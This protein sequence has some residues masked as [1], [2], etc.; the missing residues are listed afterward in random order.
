MRILLSPALAAV[1]DE[2]E[3]AGHR[4]DPW[5]PEQADAPADVVIAAGL[6]EVKMAAE[7]PCHVIAVVEETELIGVRRFGARLCDFCVAPVRDG[8]LLSRLAVLAAR[9]GRAESQLHHLMALAVEST[10]DIVEVTDTEA[11]VQYVNTAFEK[12]F[13]IAAADAI[14]KTVG[15]LIRSGAHEP[16]FFEELDATLGRGETWRGTIIS[17]ASDGRH[18]HMDSRITPIINSEGVMTHHMGV[19]RDIS[20][21][22]ARREALLE[23]NRALE[24]ARDTAVAASRAKSEFLANMSHELR[25]PLNAILGYSEMMLEDCDDGDSQVKKDLLR[26]RRAGSHLLELINDVLDISKIEA[27]RIELAP[28]SVSLMELAEGVSSTITPLAMKNNNRFVVDC[29]PGLGLIYVDRTRLRQIVLNLLSNAC[30]FTSEGEVRLTIKSVDRDGDPWIEISV[31][32]TGIGISEEEQAKLFRPFVQADSSTTRKFGGTG[33]G[34][35]IS[36][37]LVDMMQG[38]I[39]LESEPGKGATFTVCLPAEDEPTLTLPVSFPGSTGRGRDPVVLLIDDDLGVLELA[40]RTLTRR[41]F[42]VCMA[43]SG[44]EGIEMAG[45]LRPDAIL[46]DVKMPGMSGWEVLSTLKLSEATAQIPVVMLSVMRQ[47]AIG[48]ALGAVDY[49]LKPVDK[50]A[51][52]DTLRRHIHGANATVLV[53]E[54][55]EP[56]R[57]LMKRTLE[58]A[59]HGVRLAENGQVALQQLEKGAPDIIVLDLMMP[60]MDGFTFLRHLRASDEHSEVPVI[61][62]TARVLSADERNAL[63]VSAEQVIEKTAHSHEEMLELISDQIQRLIEP[64]SEP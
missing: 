2:L 14:G 57:E 18:V 56:T 19:K 45:R 35:V 7:S 4:V 16:G 23:A 34:L 52:V 33:L 39:T 10:S 53:V 30:K 63:A 37:R 62:A 44:S 28:E 26:I 64:A 41:G 47:Q 11:V 38:E 1:A 25:T 3:A 13:G 60:V 12:T 20:D 55:D 59:G 9:P 31:K 29:P 48:E 49:L 32:D 50:N 24:Q 15:A 8:E 54:D 51:L 42:R 36:K 5:Q 43:S 17:Q 61:V 27:N 21:R 6:G 22:L 58:K 40:E 46:L